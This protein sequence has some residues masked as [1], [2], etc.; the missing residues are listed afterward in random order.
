VNRTY[1]RD[2]PRPKHQMPH[3]MYDV[4]DAASAWYATE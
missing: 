1:R 3:V 2:V 4:G